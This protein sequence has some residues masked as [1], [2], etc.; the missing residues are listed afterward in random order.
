MHRRVDPMHRA[1]AIAIFIAIF[2]A[3]CFNE[4]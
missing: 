2:P 1:A 4:P 3:I